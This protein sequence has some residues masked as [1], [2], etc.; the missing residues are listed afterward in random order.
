MSNTFLNISAVKSLRSGEA[1]ADIIKKADFLN[2]TTFRGEYR[3]PGRFYRLEHISPS[4]AGDSLAKFKFQL[5]S[6][7]LHS[8]CAQCLVVASQRPGCVISHPM[9]LM[10]PHLMPCDVILNLRGCDHFRRSVLS[11]SF[12]QSGT[13]KQRRD[14]NRVQCRCSQPSC[15]SQCLTQH[16]V[17]DLHGLCRFCRLREQRYHAVPANG[18]R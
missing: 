9:Q 1:C 4:A 14:V 17:A 10:K 2:S 13:D 11:A 18:S 8:L 12:F 5:R 15:G 16:N 3:P 7:R 6:N